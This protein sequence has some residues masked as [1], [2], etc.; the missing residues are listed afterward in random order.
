MWT[1]DLQ[2]S[3]E[4]GEFR[5]SRCSPFPQLHHASWCSRHAGAPYFDR[6]R[7]SSGGADEEHILEGQLHLSRGA[8][9]KKPAIGWSTRSCAKTLVFRTTGVP[10]ER[11][12]QGK[13]NILLFPAGKVGQQKRKGRVCCRQRLGGLLKYYSYANAAELFVR[14]CIRPQRG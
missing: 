3:T 9:W 10:K 6:E 1:K 13:G 4:K 14:N 5:Y 2:K 7:W 11:N 8:R 12:Y